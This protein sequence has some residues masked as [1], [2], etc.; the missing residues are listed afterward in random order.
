MCACCGT[1]IDFSYIRAE[2]RAGRPGTWLS[3]VVAEGDNSRIYITPDEEQILVTKVDKPD[4]YPSAELPNNPRDFKTPN[5]GMTD[6]SDLFTNRQLTALTTYS[7]LVDEAQ[8]KDYRWRF[9]GIRKS[10][11]CIF[12]IWS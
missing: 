4:D 11:R 10:C 2:G 1:P 5:Y 3:A 7:E 6:F 12:G 8:A 9:R